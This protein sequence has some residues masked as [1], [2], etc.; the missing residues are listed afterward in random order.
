[1]T[2]KAKEDQAESGVDGVLGAMANLDL[3]LE[4]I[5]D[6]LR[7]PSSDS[8]DEL[9]S[10]LGLA[11]LPSRS[12]IEASLVDRFLTPK[13]A[14]PRHWLDDWQEHW[15]DEARERDVRRFLHIDRAETRTSLEWDWEGLEGK[16]K[17]YKEVR[18]GLVTSSKKALWSARAGLQACNRPVG[19]VRQGISS[20][21]SSPDCAVYFRRFPSL[22]IQL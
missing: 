20:S 14:I 5:F 12:Q 15:H 6:S 10:D 8:K 3:S 17:G 1:M 7:T 19:L 4:K 21:R 13:P 2:V 22:T 16:V 9:L 11:S 18:S